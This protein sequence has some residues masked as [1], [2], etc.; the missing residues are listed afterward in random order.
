MYLPGAAP[1]LKNVWLGKS[2]IFRDTSDAEG[3]AARNAKALAA[4]VTSVARLLARP[5]LQCPHCTLAE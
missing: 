1:H 5:D 4:D 3:D 2:S